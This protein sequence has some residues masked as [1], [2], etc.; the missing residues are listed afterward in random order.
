MK[1]QLFSAHA[2]LPEGTD[3]YENFKYVALVLTIDGDNGTILE[4]STP[5]YCNQTSAF[6][7]DI[8]KGRSL[9]TDVSFI[10]AEIEGRMHT[11]SKRALITAVQMIHNRYMTTKD[12][13]RDKGI[14]SN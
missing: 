9:E 1:P 4:C 7:A 12:K 13:N 6:V 2:Q 14:S 5:V 8:M 10:I 3:L 11:G